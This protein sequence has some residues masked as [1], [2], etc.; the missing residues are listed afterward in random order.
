MYA[1]ETEK[2]SK[3]FQTVTAVDELNLQVPQGSIFGFLGPNGAGK[4]TTLQILMGFIKPSSGTAFIL[5]EK[6]TLNAGQ[7][8]RNTG[9]LPDVP[10]F[11]NW[12]RARE[13]LTFSGEL[14]GM[15][16]T[17]LKSRVDELLE[18]A[19]LAGVKTKIGGFS[20]GMKQRLG[21]AHALIHEPAVVMLDEP[22][23]ALDPIG[24]K[25][26]L[27]MIAH[28]AGRTTILLSTHILAD[29]ER[30]CDTV[31]ILSEGRLIAQESIAHLKKRYI[32]P[33][34]SIRVLTG[35]ENLAAML[36]PAEWVSAVQVEDD[37]LRVTVTDLETAQ[38]RLPG[39]IA[40]SGCGLKEL[41]PAET[42]LEDIFVRL[43]RN[44]EH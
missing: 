41:S 21:L 20:R 25:Q 38:R 40:D 1:I 19:D 39:L 23:S 11:Y 22:T 13:F 16:R 35:A 29:V 6:V 31:A 37:V 26:V 14:A 32:Q 2:L 33:V 43:V 36:R 8:R 7:Y 17:R 24:R 12:M 4:T 44:H 10:S 15:E 18:I 28:F 3:R 30:V 9:Y 34:V 42:T 27:D 5:G